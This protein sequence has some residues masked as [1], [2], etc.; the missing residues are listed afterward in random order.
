MNVLQINADQLRWDALACAGNSFV[1]TPNLDRLAREGV[2]FSSAFTPQ[3]MCVAARCSLHSGLSIY[4]THCTITFENPEEWYFGAGSWDQCLARAGYHSEYHGRWHAPLPLTEGYANEVTLDF[5]SPY[6]AWLRERVGEPPAPRL[7][8]YRDVI[9]G[10]PYAPD[11][12]DYNLRKAQGDEP[13][14]HTPGVEYGVYEL[15]PEHTFSGFV[16]DRLIEAMGRLREGPF[17]LSAGILAPHHPQQVTR[18]WSESVRPEDLPPPVSMHHKRENTPF[19][20]TPWQIDATE[21]ANMGLIQARYYQLVQEV[22][23]Q[24]GRVLNELDA[25][26]LAEDT[27]VLFTADH[28]EF[29]GD[30]GLTQKFYPYQEAIRVPL[31]MRLPGRIPAGRVVAEPVNLTDVFATVLDYTGQAKMGKEN[32]ESRSLRPLIEGRAQGWPD[33]T[34]SEFESL[35]W[36]ALISREWKYVWTRLPEQQDLLFDLTA[37]PQELNNLLGSNPDRSRYLDQAGRLKQQLLGWM[38]SINHPYREALASAEIG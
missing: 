6:R 21:I 15:A 24:V 8:Q 36:H 12:P 4:T 29:L 5:A 20:A 32:T 7:G 34:V 16:A 1:Q 25:L 35:P 14:H 26:G 23:A 3:P 11:A 22:D 13:G 2:R 19:Q 37:D 31:L 17:S 27:L 10:W 33:F 38:E 28:G 18:A 9:S 30:H